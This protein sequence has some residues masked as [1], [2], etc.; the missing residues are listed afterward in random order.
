MQSR[1][2]GPGEARAIAGFLRHS[3]AVTDAG[4]ES[5][6]LDKLLAEFLAG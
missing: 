1:S 5:L 3:Y 2:V 6:D 4:E